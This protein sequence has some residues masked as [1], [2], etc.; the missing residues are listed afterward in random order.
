MVE[1]SKGAKKAWATRRKKKWKRKSLDDK[2][3]ELLVIAKKKKKK[4][5]VKALEH[6]YRSNAR[7][8]QVVQE[9][10]EALFPQD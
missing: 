6:R 10:K 5:L 9:I 3:Q 7:R 4:R 1:M 8:R 2:V